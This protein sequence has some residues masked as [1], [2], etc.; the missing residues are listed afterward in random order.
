MGMDNEQIIRQVTLLAQT[1]QPQCN[2]LGFASERGYQGTG[3]FRHRWQDISPLW[4]IVLVKVYNILG[5]LILPIIPFW[6]AKHHIRTNT[7]RL[8]HSA[9]RNALV[10]LRKAGTGGHFLIWK[11]RLFVFD[12]PDYPKS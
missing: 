3:R 9:F 8:A 4:D 7:L 6:L 12:H 5:L 1:I 10:R 2:Y 11:C